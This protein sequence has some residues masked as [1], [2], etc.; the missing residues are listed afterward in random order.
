MASRWFGT[1]PFTGRDAEVAALR[2]RARRACEGHGGVQLVA[3]PPGY[4]KTRLVDEAFRD[5]ATGVSL[6]LRGSAMDAA[7]APPLWP[8]RQALRRRVEFPSLP[9]DVAEDTDR[10]VAARFQVLAASAD[11]VL[12]LAERLGPVVVVLE[13]LHWADSATLALLEHLG[14]VLA[15]V[16]LLL[17]GTTR[18]PAAGSPLATTM[19]ALSRAPHT[20]SLTLHPLDHRAV[21]ACLAALSS[22]DALIATLEPAEVHART[23]GV[24]L[25]LDAAVHAGSAGDPPADPGHADLAVTV[26]RLLAGLAHGSREALAAAALLGDPVDVHVLAAVLGLDV[27]ATARCVDAAVAQRLL[28]ADPPMGYRFRHALVRD[29]VAA[30]VAPG[31]VAEIHRRAAA[32]LARA[33]EHDPDLS[34]RVAAHHEAAGGDPTSHREAARWWGR[35]AALAGRRLAVDDAVRHRERAVAAEARAGASPEERGEALIHLATA[36]FLAGRYAHSVGHCQEAAAFA[37]EA[38]RVELLAAAA[39]VVRGVIYPE[40]GFALGR[41]CDEALAV[42]ALDAGTRARLLA[43]RAGLW[44]MGGSDDESRRAADD[45]VESLRLAE[46]DGRPEILLDALQARHGTLHHPR[47]AAERLALADRALGAAAVVGSPLAA[48][49]AHEW[50]ARA[51]MDLGD[52]GGAEDAIH[53]IGALA[54]ESRLPLARWH[55]LRGVTAI[56]LL[57]GRFDAARQAN[58]EA[59]SIA[60]SGGDVVARLMGAA[61]ALS[62]ARLRGDL[63]EIRAEHLAAMTAVGLQ[64]DVSRGASGTIAVLEGRL[65]EAAGVLEELR[66]RDGD[67]DVDGL[68]GA[69]L[70]HLVTLAEAVGDRAA[71]ARIAEQ[72]QPFLAAGAGFGAPTIEW[73]GPTQRDIGRMLRVAGRP[74]EAEKWLREGVDAAVALRARPF[75]VLGRLDL[76]GTLAELG[77][78]ARLLEAEALARDAGREARRLDMPGAVQRVDELVRRIAAVRREA[79]PLSPRE[80]EVEQLVLRALSNREI[81]ERLVVSE[82]TV[83]SHVRNILAKLGC[84]NR[85]ELLARAGE[86][87]QA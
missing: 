30:T 9:A 35:A 41:L 37:R 56:G 12:D 69:V 59:T 87:S 32:V 27:A 86:R 82:R 10:A 5:E 48:V 57:T 83:E 23:G 43:Q 18:P 64:N 81:A 34:G 74:D 40:A 46:S 28:V 77:G 20:E 2:A 14:P 6:V 3:A 85:T 7:G 4:G 31:D 21:A 26:D 38:G 47:T 33:A 1:L 36:E 16:P 29:A 72:L 24:P 62:L 55:H 52:P 42:G 60:E 71:A 15:D 45:A 25:L 54:R 79:D 84:A 65:D 51:C 53:G 78:A 19:A 80:R 76:A 68:W 73:A 8:W 17:V 11:A 49:L 50:R 75:V 44:A 58:D 61:A 70:M 13:D 22:Q 39:L 67:P 63:R 66:S